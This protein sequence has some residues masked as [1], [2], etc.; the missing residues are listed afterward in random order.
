M[1]NSRSNEF[2]IVVSFLAGAVVAAGLTLLLAPRAGREVREKLAD[3]KDETVN[4][5]REC[6]REAR[7]KVSPKTRKDA[8]YYE[9]G[10]CWI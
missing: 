4:K 9:G 1:S 5:I 3:V 10:D 6:A 2:P 7:F 8:F